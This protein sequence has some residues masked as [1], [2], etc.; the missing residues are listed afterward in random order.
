MR[1]SKRCPCFCSLRYKSRPKNKPEPGLSVI[2]YSTRGEV[3]KVYFISYVVDNSLPVIAT[4]NAVLD[5]CRSNGIQLGAELAPQLPQLDEIITLDEDQS[6]RNVLTLFGD[7]NFLQRLSEI[8]PHSDLTPAQRSLLTKQGRQALLAKIA[9]S[10]EDEETRDILKAIDM[11]S[12][13]DGDVK[14]E[15][16]TDV[17]IN[18]GDT[19]IAV[20]PPGE[21]ADIYNRL[22]G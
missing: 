2:D 11:L 22:L 7:L 20:L 12:K 15:K 8:E 3:G 6:F 14:Q 17:S 10:A 16:K 5:I 18:I 19:N 21:A 13:L 1:L 4:R 9:D